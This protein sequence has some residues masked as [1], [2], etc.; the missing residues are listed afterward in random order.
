MQDGYYP[1]MQF[2]I[3]GAMSFTAGLAAFK[4]PET[5]N[6]PM[7]E[8]FDDL[9][10]KEDRSKVKVVPLSEDKVKLMEGDILERQ[11]DLEDGVEV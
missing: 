7:P 4:L 2:F 9:D 11:K 10:L 8:T 6:K 1:L 3:F 5:V